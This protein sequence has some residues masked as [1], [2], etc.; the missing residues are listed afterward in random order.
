MGWR[1]WSTSV[2]SYIIYLTDGYIHNE[3][4]PF[5]IGIPDRR[6]LEKD[7][8]FL[9]GCSTSLLSNF[10]CVD[11]NAVQTDFFLFS[12]VAYATVLS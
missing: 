10:V 7:K 8:R 2:G 3:L 11:A 4:E 9:K 12:M 1:Q 6:N 5:T